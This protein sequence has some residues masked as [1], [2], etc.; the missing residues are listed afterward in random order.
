MK[1]T[2]KFLV[3]LKGCKKT[4]LKGQPPGTLAVKEFTVE[5]TKKKMES[6][7]FIKWLLDEKDDFRDE[8]I[9]VDIE[10]VKNDKTPN[11]KKK[12]S[13]KKDR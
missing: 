8:V 1:I 3:Q 5:Q 10:E 7:M 13:C 6:P 11:K 12:R 9:E 4:F 2:I